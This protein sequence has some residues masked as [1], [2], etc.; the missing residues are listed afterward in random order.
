MS[1]EKLT[2][3]SVSKYLAKAKEDLSF[4]E[5]VEVLSHYLIDVGSEKLIEQPSTMMSFKNHRG[6]ITVQQN[7]QSVSIH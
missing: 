6:K 2:K 4:E 1:K 7:Y 5:F 3:E